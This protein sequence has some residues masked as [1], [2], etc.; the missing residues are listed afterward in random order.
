MMSENY[1]SHLC[2]S[3][4]SFRFY[5]VCKGDQVPVDLFFDENGLVS[6]ESQSK[7][8]VGLSLSEVQGLVGDKGISVCY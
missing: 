3:A 7:N 4:T 5:F 2:G 6:S 1:A 8:L